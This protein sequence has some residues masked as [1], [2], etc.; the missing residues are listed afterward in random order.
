MHEF[1]VF[2]FIIHRDEHE[3]LTTLLRSRLVSSS[4]VIVQPMNS[5]EAEPELVEGAVGV[6]SK[7]PSEEEDDEPCGNLVSW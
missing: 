4:N 7:I 6:E 1:V 5:L 3:R 2:F